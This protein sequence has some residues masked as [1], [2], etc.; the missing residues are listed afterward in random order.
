[1][2]TVCPAPLAW[3]RVFEALEEAWREQGSS[4]PRPP[5]PLILNGWVYSNDADKHKRWTE[6]VE[7][8]SERGLAGILGQLRDSDFYRV[9]TFSTYEVG[10][11]GGPMFLPWS[12]DSKPIPTHELL[13]ESLS[14]LKAEWSTIASD[15]IAEITTPVKFTRRKRRRLVVRVSGN[16]D[17]PWGTRNTLAR[18]DTRKRFTELRAKVNATIAPHMVDHIDF[19]R[20]KI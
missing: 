4:G 13:T 20:E 18:D 9:S 17:P 15:G 7:W 16:D 11:G 5:A 12:F 1:M 2:K 14:K 19:F 6:L 3:L 10:P 8:A